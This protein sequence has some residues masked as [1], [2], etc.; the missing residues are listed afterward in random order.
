[1]LLDPRATP[2]KGSVDHNAYQDGWSTMA[3][4]WRLPI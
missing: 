4:W 3:K 2:D 1:V